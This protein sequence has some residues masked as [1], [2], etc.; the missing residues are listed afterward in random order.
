MMKVVAQYRQ[1]ANAYRQM[2]AH[3]SRQDDKKT[4]EI[5]AE[6]WE[7]LANLRERDLETDE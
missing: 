7:K 1:N 2:A 3:E 5:I 4:L 6:A